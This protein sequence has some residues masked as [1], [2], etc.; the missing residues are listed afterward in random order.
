MEIEFGIRFLDGDVGFLLI[1]P[2][3]DVRLGFL[4]VSFG[5]W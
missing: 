3:L 2:I 1:I 4:G 5:E